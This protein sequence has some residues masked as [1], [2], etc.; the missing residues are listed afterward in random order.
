MVKDGELTLDTWVAGG[1]GS[2][3]PKLGA[4]SGPG[5][6]LAAGELFRV[7][8]VSGNDGVFGMLE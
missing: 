4:A 8:Q 1:R 2:E 7:S 3:Q 5:S 6:A